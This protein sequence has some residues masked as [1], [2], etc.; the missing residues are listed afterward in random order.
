MYKMILASQSPR[1]RELL[2]LA[3][4]NFSVIPSNKE[5]VITG[6]IPSEVVCEL[7]SQKAWAVFEEYMAAANEAG[8]TDS[9]TEEESAMPIVIGADTVVSV[10]GKI[11]GKPRD[12]QDAFDMI[13]QLQGRTHQ[14]YT[15]VSVV[16]SKG[17]INTFYECTG[18]T[19]YPMTDEEI[20]SYIREEDFTWKD[21]AGAYGIQNSFGARFI[22]NIEGDYYNVVGLPIARLFHELGEMELKEFI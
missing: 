11:L 13:K 4:F 10:D 9:T 14:V 19:L 16:K 18:V 12:E 21:K 22:K 3:G 6:I 1:R 8:N 17:E 7:S 2:T 20:W 5:E 15:G